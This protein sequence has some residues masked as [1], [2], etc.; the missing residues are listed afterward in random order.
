MA[1]KT[2]H[3]NDCMFTYSDSIGAATL[4]VHVIISLPNCVNKRVSR[5]F[6]SVLHTI[7]L[8]QDLGKQ[9]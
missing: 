3:T 2:F 1:H 7:I 9:D 6:I 5:C 8:H 4:I